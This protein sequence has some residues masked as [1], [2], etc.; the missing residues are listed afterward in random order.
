MSSPEEIVRSFY[1][2]WDTA[3]FRAAFEQYLHPDVLKEDSGFGATP[4][5]AMTMQGLEAYLETFNRP[6]A[7]VE[8]RNLAVT[9]NTVLTERT[10]YCENRETGDRYVG[11]LMSVF[12]IEGDRI[13]PSSYQY[14]K[15]MP[16]G[17]ETRKLMKL[18]SERAKGG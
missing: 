12:V 7:R 4:G 13:D 5:K 11:H 10:E 14:G 1:K 17:P 8:I 16:R 3:G 15:A 2:A 9:G 18:W 6:F